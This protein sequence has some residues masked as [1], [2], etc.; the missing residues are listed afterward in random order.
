MV[1]GLGNTLNTFQPGYEAQFWSDVELEIVDDAEILGKSRQMTDELNPS[2]VLLYDSCQ[3]HKGEDQIILRTHQGKITYLEHILDHVQ[4]KMWRS[5]RLLVVASN[6]SALPEHLHRLPNNV[7]LI[8]GLN[9]DVNNLPPTL[10]SDRLSV[11]MIFQSFRAPWMTAPS[12]A[13]FFKALP[14]PSRRLIVDELG[15]WDA[16]LRRYRPYAHHLALQVLS[17]IHPYSRGRIIRNVRN[18]LLCGALPQ[19]DKSLSK[20]YGF[21]LALATFRPEVLREFEHRPPTSP[22]RPFLQIQHDQ[23]LVLVFHDTPQW[24]RNAVDAIVAH[25]AATLVDLSCRIP[26]TPNRSGQKT[27][28]LAIIEQQWSFFLHCLNFD[29][30]PTV[31]IAAHSEK[32]ECGYTLNSLLE[33]LDPKDLLQVFQGQAWVNLVMFT[34]YGNE[35]VS[36]HGSDMPKGATLVSTTPQEE[37][38]WRECFVPDMN[39]CELCFAIALGI[40]QGSLALAVSACDFY[41]H[42]VITYNPQSEFVWDVHSPA[43]RKINQIMQRLGRDVLNEKSS[44][45]HR[46]A[47]KLSQ[48]LECALS[49]VGCE[50]QGVIGY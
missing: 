27:S 19:T 14:E 4:A 9:V 35:I 24:V 38:L 18:P 49:E 50:S 31:V 3:Y 36:S 5:A 26:R 21:V 29:T 22:L 25:T 2:V 43:H 23:T 46:I 8:T 34:E 10:M 45:P 47:F 32:T 28:L 48:K 13:I 30:V 15:E 37:K 20:I 39:F 33:R 12:I 7:V 42:E 16:A 40:D 11:E 41:Q 6:S 44:G 1:N 17:G